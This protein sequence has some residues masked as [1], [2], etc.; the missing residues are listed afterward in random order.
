MTE[1]ELDEFDDFDDAE[2]I[3]DHRPRTSS[4]SA[5]A[6]VTQRSIQSFFSRPDTSID[7]QE[8]FPDIDPPESFPDAEAAGSVARA[9]PGRPP[10]GAIPA[11]ASQKL[12]VSEV[13]GEE[14]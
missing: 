6:A 9:R 13:F 11:S 12:R 5:D 14:V 2:L 10:S 8:S 4:S 1:A 3:E 7:P